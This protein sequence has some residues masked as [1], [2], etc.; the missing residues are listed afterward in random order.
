[1]VDPITSRNT[2]K[3]DFL[4]IKRRMTPLQKGDLRRAPWE[5][6]HRPRKVLTQLKFR[7]ERYGNN[8][9]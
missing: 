5:V 7:L 8:P 2:P 1:M 9:L 4:Y 6:L 3:N